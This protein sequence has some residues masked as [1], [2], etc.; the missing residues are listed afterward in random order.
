MLALASLPVH[1]ITHAIS[2]IET[3][4]GNGENYA[5]SQHDFNHEDKLFLHNPLTHDAERFLMIEKYFAAN[6]QLV[7]GGV[8]WD[9]LNASLKSIHTLQRRSYLNHIKIPVLTLMGSKDRVTPPSESEHYLSY[10]QHEEH[11]IIQGALHD[12]LNES[13]NYRQEAWQHIDTFLSKII[14]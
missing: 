6:P 10:L 8:T 11:K 5:T 2:W 12:I 14:P 7:V 4:L 9:W 3:K 13:D 1:T